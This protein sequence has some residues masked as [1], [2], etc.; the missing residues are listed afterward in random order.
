MQEE[1]TYTIKMLANQNVGNSFFFKGQTY[2]D[3]P[4]SCLDMIS[5]Y[6]IIETEQPDD[7]EK[8]QRPVSDKQLK[9]SKNKSRSKAL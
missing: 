8:Q 2:T 3:I 5:H 7:G 4:Q 1:K 6:Q 9:I